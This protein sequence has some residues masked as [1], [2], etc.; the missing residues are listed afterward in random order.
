MLHATSYTIRHAPKTNTILPNIY[1][2][3]SKKNRGTSGAKK[4]VDMDKEDFLS[5]SFVWGISRRIVSRLTAQAYS[6][7]GMMLGPIVMALKILTSRACEIMGPDELDEP[8]AAKDVNFAKTIGKT[9]QEL[10]QIKNL[11]PFPKEAV[12]EGAEVIGFGSHADGGAPGYSGNCYIYSKKEEDIYSNM[13]T[14][15][16]KVSKRTIPANE[17]LARPL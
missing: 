15:K 6:R 11:K 4:L 8:I 12:P 2:N 1:F 14:N 16:S 10:P 5:K 7:L 17:T 9:C 13:I 3:L